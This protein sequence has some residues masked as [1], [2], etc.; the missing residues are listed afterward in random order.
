MRPLLFCF[1]HAGGSTRLFRGWREPLAHVF[2][3][4]PIELPGRGRH[5]NE[6]PQDRLEPL[7]ARVYARSELRHERP[8]AVFGHS[9]GALVAF[10]LARLLRR[11]TGLEP[12]HL[13]VSALGAPHALA[14]AG[15]GAGALSDDELR[16]QIR[17]IGAI[18][19]KLARR[20]ALL[21]RQLSRM[22]PVLRADLAVVEHYRHVSAEPFTCPLTALGGLGDPLVDIEALEAWRLHTRGAF[23]MEL[24]DGDHF[25][26]DAHRSHV[27][28][29]LATA[30]RPDANAPRYAQSVL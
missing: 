15:C 26:L 2:D 20:P 30:A 7:L 24:M 13:F 28:R 5:W 8:F 6:T 17:G 23:A 29:V 18:S 9:L 3:V 4:C 27:L 12:I 1:A 21:Q 25:F 10:E 14:P 16:E 22:L 19:P 11:R